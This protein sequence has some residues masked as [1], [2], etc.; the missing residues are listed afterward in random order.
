MSNLNDIE[1]ELDEASST[2]LVAFRLSKDLDASLGAKLEAAITRYPDH[3]SV[4]GSDAEI[5]LLLLLSIAVA[6]SYFVIHRLGEIKG[7][8]Q[9]KNTN[10]FITAMHEK[11]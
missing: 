1:K 3:L 5:V 2:F 11:R 10:L 8:A 7:A 9:M 4:R 6:L